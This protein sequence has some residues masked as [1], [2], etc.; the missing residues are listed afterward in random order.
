MIH[1]TS[2]GLRRQEGDE[3]AAFLVPLSSWS[4]YRLECMKTGRSYIGATEHLSDRL[5]AHYNGPPKGLLKD[6][7]PWRGKKI[8]LKTRKDWFTDQVRV[9]IEATGMWSLRYASQQ[10][11]RYIAMYPNNYNII[12]S[13]PPNRCR[14]GYAIMASSRKRK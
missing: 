3:E 13:G 10:E 12:K 11:G 4:I 7:D 14:Q 5:A 8:E 1:N 6:M 2:A 9:H